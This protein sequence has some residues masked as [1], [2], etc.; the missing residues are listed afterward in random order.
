MQRATLLFLL[1]ALFSP[2]LAGQAPS[3]AGL[4]KRAADNRTVCLAANE[5]PQYAERQLSLTDADVRKNEKNCLD[6]DQ[7]N[8]KNAHMRALVCDDL[9]AEF[10][11]FQADD[12]HLSYRVSRT[13]ESRMARTPQPG[14]RSVEQS[15]WVWTSADCTN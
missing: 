14:P 3:R 9:L 6:G 15:D 12:S 2:A 4:W 5:A 7:A 1:V 13:K 11:V 10:G 8:W